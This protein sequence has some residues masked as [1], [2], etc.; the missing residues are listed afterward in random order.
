MAFQISQSHRVLDATRRHT[1]IVAGPVF[2]HVEGR[3]AVFRKNRVEQMRERFG[4]D[5]PTDIGLGL[6]RA[7]FRAAARPGRTGRIKHIFGR[8]IIDAEIIHLLVDVGHVGGMICRQ[9]IADLVVQLLRIGAVEQG[10]HEGTIVEQEGA[11]RCLFARD[12]VV[13][14]IDRLDIE[15][16]ADGNVLSYG[17]DRLRPKPMGQ[18]EV[19]HRMHGGFAVGQARRMDAVEMAE[20]GRAPRFVERGHCFKPVAEAQHHLFGIV[21]KG[22]RRVTVAPSAL[23]FEHLRQVPMIERRIGFHAARKASV[24]ETLVEV[25]T[26]LV[27]LA[28]TGRNDPRPG[29]RKAI[30]VDTEGFQQIKIRIEPVIMVAGR[31]AG[32]TLGHLSRC[33]GKRVPNRGRAPVLADGTF[34]LVGSCRRSEH[35][36]GGKPPGHILCTRHCSHSP[37]DGSLCYRRPIGLATATALTGGTHGH[38]NARRGADCCLGGCGLGSPE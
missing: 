30:A 12:T 3:Q 13:T 9:K 15:H 32:V 17:P 26:G 16:D 6:V 29:D 5:V 22:P 31:R 2:H 23:V 36:I 20:I 33:G 34:D 24:D 35:E 7:F 38:D 4:H 19:M 27:D 14:R 28:E 21:G 11:P 8:V 37:S 10:P 25:E 1:G 18:I